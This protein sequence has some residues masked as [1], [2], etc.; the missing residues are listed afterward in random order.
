MAFALRGESFG[1]PRTQ[2]PQP[3]E[4]TK[5]RCKR[6][7][8]RHWHS[9]DMPLSTLHAMGVAGALLVLPHVRG[10]VTAPM[11]KQQKPEVNERAPFGAEPASQFANAAA[12]AHHRAGAVLDSLRSQ[13]GLPSSSHHGSKTPRCIDL[14]GHWRKN[15]AESDSLRCARCEARRCQVVSLQSWASCVRE[16]ASVGRGVGFKSTSSK[17][18]RALY[19]PSQSCVREDEAQPD[20]P[21]GRRPRLLS[22]REKPPL[23]ESENERSENGFLRRGGLAVP[24]SLSRPRSRRP[25]TTGGRQISQGPEEF[26]VKLKAGILGI[27]ERS[28]GTYFP[29]LRY[30]AASA[31]VAVSEGASV[32]CPGGAFLRYP[33]TGE[34]REYA[35]RDKRRGNAR[36]RVEMLR[37]GG[38]E[39]VRLISEWDDPHAGARIMLQRALRRLPLLPR[40]AAATPS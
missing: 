27:S 20:H 26:E 14:T 17:L 10:W 40:S 4:S 3:T 9:T 1:L 5:R 12:T 8:R 33:M 37:Q 39:A 13:M 30:L 35:R 6:G 28:A 24:M 19:F 34:V 21:Q 22:S 32:A 36:T 18:E 23:V 29:P 2:E 11:R 7:A 25:T 31:D 38:A 16:R 15:H